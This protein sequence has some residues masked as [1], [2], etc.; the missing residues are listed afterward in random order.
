MLSNL[1]RVGWNLKKCWHHLLYAD[2][3]VFLQQTN[4]KK[5]ENLLKMVNIEEENFWTTE[6]F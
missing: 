2:V 4:I 1:F 3:I 6:E 5:S